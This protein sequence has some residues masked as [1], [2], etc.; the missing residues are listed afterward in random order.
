VRS[1]SLGLIFNVRQ[2]DKLHETFN[3]SRLPR[4]D[5]TDDT[6]VDVAIRPLRNIFE[7]INFFQ[8]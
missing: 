2:D 3:E 6:Q 1:R 4:S 8:Q 7:N 5:S